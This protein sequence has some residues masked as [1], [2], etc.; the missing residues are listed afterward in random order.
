LLFGNSTADTARLYNYTHTIRSFS[1]VAN[2]I[3]VMFIAL[4]ANLKRELM[5]NAEPQSDIKRV[6]K[7]N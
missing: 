7:E 6:F 3:V 4:I 5:H 1:F 2:V